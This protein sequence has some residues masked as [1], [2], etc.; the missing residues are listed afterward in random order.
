[1]IEEGKKGKREVRSSFHV[2]CAQI[3]LAIRKEERERVKQKGLKRV[4]YVRKKSVLREKKLKIKSG[5]LIPLLLPSYTHVKPRG[6]SFIFDS[7]HILL[8]LFH[9][10]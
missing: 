2:N 3:K 9:N 10:F 1:M 5:V 7:D 4:A 8:L 6:K